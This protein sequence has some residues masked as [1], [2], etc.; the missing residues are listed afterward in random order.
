MTGT[1]AKKFI[2]IA[3][4]APASCPP[5]LKCHWEHFLTFSVPNSHFHCFT[6]IN[7][8]GIIKHHACITGH[9]NNLQ[10]IDVVSLLSTLKRRP[11][12]S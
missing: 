6:T 4:F 3:L 10:C 2:N 9:R 7:T 12:S 8:E 5:L 11:I 1:P